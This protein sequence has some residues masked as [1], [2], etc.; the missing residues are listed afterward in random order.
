MRPRPLFWLFLS[1]FFFIA[2]FYMW[3]LADRWEAEKAA[4]SATQGPEGKR[5]NQYSVFSVQYSAPKAQ[6][7]SLNTPPPPPST[8]NSQPLPLPPDEQQQDRRR[9]GP[10]RKGDLAGERPGG[11]RAITRPLHSRPSARARRS[12]QLHRPIARSAE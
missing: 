11:H 1:L 3:R 4:A 9:V 5:S 10:Q 7:G 6:A 12:W 2:G 8:L